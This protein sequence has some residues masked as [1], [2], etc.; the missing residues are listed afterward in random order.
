MQLNLGFTSPN[1]QQQPRSSP[2]A[3]EAATPWHKLHPAVQ[4]DALQILAR[5][6]AAMLAAALTTESRHE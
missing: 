6:I 1:D 3:A 5:I 2:T 4:A